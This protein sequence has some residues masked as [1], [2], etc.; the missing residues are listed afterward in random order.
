MYLL[1][2]RPPLSRALVLL[3]FEESLKLLLTI[4][5]LL[6]FFSGRP[7]AMVGATWVWSLVAKLCLVVLVGS[8][9]FCCVASTAA[10]FCELTVLLFLTEASDFCALAPEPLLFFALLEAASCF[11]SFSAY[12]FFMTAV[13]PSKKP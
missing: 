2:V 3:F 7:A 1:L 5:L 4:A 10:G 12:A 8:A 13:I 6:L 11:F 9:T